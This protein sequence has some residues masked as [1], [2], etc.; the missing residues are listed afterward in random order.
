MAKKSFALNTE[1][2]VASVGDAELLFQPEVMGDEFMDALGELREAQKAASGIDLE[3]LQTLDPDALRSASRGL[4]GFLA[5]L[6]LPESAELFT[7]LDV[8][9]DGAVVASYQDRD[10]AQ[11]HADGIEGA[12]VL[13]A[14]RLPDRVLVELMEWVTEL[15][16]GGAD[17]RPPTSSSAS[18]P[19]S[20]KGGRRGMG[21]SPSRVSTPAAGR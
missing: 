17:Q 18:A 7:R 11:K 21:V 16:G 5:Q 6:M 9:A 13:D 20:Q 3:D 1:P 10:E 2:H 12:R 14:L 8:V 4:R 15:Y 19:R